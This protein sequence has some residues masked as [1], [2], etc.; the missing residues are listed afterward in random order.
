MIG[1]ERRGLMRD[2]NESRTIEQ[3]E[4]V[5]DVSELMRMERTDQASER[6]TNQHL[7]IA[8]GFPGKRSIREEE[9]RRVGGQN[10]NHSRHS[11]KK[12]KGSSVSLQ[13]TREGWFDVQLLTVN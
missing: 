9:G 8:S 10:D 6:D 5:C 1:K 13:A 4:N 11:S 7:L 3:K 12:T 2:G